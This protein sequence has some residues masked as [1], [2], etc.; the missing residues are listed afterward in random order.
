M[1]HNE[2]IEYVGAL[3]SK[4]MEKSKI[5]ASL[6]IA[7]AILES[8]YGTSELAVHAKA[9]FGIKVNGWTGRVYEK[10]TGEYYN[11][12]YVTVVAKF[13]AYDSWEQSISDH[14]NYLLTREKSAGVLRYENLI[15]ET[16]YKRACENI[17][18]DGYATSPTYAK[19][20]ISLIETY[21]LTRFDKGGKP[22]TKKVF[23]GVGHGGSDPG[24]VKYLVEK[25]VNLTMALACKAVLEA[26]GVQVKMSRT[27]DENDPIAQE[28]AE[29]NAFNPDL[30]VDVHNNAGGGDGFE[31][32]VT[33][34]GGTGRVLAKNIEAEVLKLGQNSRGLKTR[35]NSSGS[36]YYGFIRSIRCPSI[37]LE[38]V[39]VDNANDAKIADTKAEQEA[40]GRAYARGILKTL[41]ISETVKPPKPTEPTKPDKPKDN[42]YRVRKSWPG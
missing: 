24:A 31:A 36:D 5:L 11:G 19:K 30:A 3:A 38:G 12:K 37:I 7:Q 35:V 25:D 33:V 22:M 39:F 1:T 4:D 2:F 9:L 13:R 15:G 14:S 17:Q 18:K 10:K 8:A 23:I 6:T 20:L 34:H 28:I 27:R 32:L 26:N 21:N 29:C 40:F 42:M 41:G 16:N